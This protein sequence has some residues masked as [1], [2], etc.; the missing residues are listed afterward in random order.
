MTDRYLTNEEKKKLAK[1]EY[2]K[3]LNEKNDLASINEKIKN[4]YLID[5][6][7]DYSGRFKYNI[8]L[9][10]KTPIIIGIGGDKPKYTFKTDDEYNKWRSDIIKQN[11]I[12]VNIYN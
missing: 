4:M 12:I 2:N 8:Y 10:T 3:I 5:K 11:D 7:A 1:E 6:T 9:K